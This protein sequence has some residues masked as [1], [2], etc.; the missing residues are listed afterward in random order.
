MFYVLHKSYHKISR[1]NQKFINIWIIILP[2][3][4]EKTPMKHLY[5]VWWQIFSKNP[6]SF[7]NLE[8]MADTNWM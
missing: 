3:K 5:V 2:G 8:K 1:N 4:L 6:T 7:D